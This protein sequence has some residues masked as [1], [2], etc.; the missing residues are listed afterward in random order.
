M[1]QLLAARTIAEELILPQNVLPEAEL[2][3]DDDQE[4]VGPERGERLVVVD[5]SHP[6]WVEVNAEQ[7]ERASDPESG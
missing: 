4:G 2:A 3:A 7:H 6:L 5:R 1:G